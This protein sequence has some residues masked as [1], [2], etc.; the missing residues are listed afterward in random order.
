MLNEKYESILNNVKKFKNDYK[1]EKNLFSLGGRGHYENPITDLLKFFFNPSEEHNFQDLF[2]SSLFQLLGVSECNMSYTN[3]IKCSREVYTKEGNRIDLLIENEDW[4]VVIENKIRHDVS[5][6]L[7]E[8]HRFIERMY[9][10]K[11]KIF[12]VL[13]PQKRSVPSNWRLILYDD[14][15]EIIS[16]NLGSYLLNPTMNP[17]SKWIFFLREF[18][19]N[20]KEQTGAEAM[21]KGKVK[22]VNKNYDEINQLIKLR[23]EYFY[24]IAQ[25]CNE[26]IAKEHP[27]AELLNQTQSWPVGYAVRSYDQNNWAKRTN[28]AFV[29]L[30]NGEFRIQVY[31]YEI[32]QS[33]SEKIERLKKL[34]GDYSYWQE[35]KNTINCFRKGDYVNPEDAFKEL[36]EAAKKLNKFYSNMR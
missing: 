25:R 20:I 2:L 19:L 13:A 6:P 15:H 36:K 9:P 24:Y 5:N 34:F 7:D 26:I 8:Y 35:G 14:L 32:E 30:D 21:D 31:V 18:L 12:L 28:I 27:E 17:N 11:R 33:M 16:S 1:K 4:V 29:I 3:S 22:F 10:K 23:D